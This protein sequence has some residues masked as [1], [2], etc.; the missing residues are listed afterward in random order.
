MNKDLQNKIKELI[1]QENNLHELRSQLIKFHPYDLAQ[2]FT[3]LEPED[4]LKIYASLNDQELADLFS[5]LEEDDSADYLEELDLKKGAAVLEKME[6]DDAADILKELDDEKQVQ[7]YLNLLDGEVRDDLSYLSRQDEKT[8]GSLMTTNYIEIPS[9]V[10]VKEA[11]RIL[12][13]EANET[14]VI[15]PLYVCEDKKLVGI[16]SLKDLIIARGPQLIKDIMKTN[17]VSV[18]VQEDVVDAALKI[19]DYGITTLPVLDKGELV[20]IITIDDAM[21]IIEDDASAHYGKFAG[22]VHDIDDETNVFKTLRK[23]LPWLLGL[24]ALSFLIS[25][26]IDSFEGVIKQVTALVFFQSLILSMAGNI[27]TQALAV[28]IRGLSYGDTSG[29]PVA[30]FKEFKIGLINSLLLGLLAFVVAYL[31]LFI[32]KSDANRLLVAGILAFSMFLALNCSAFLGVMIPIFFSKIKIDPAIASG[33]LLTTLNDIASVVIYYGLASIF[34][35]L[36]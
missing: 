11:M 7:E 33:P 25:T 32:T 15:D 10:D 17:L 19:R 29:K 20:G 36:L 5:Y 6:S 21:D 3:E 14:E 35:R 16:I 12:I 18:D 27:S 13:K 23:R 9:Q 22:I 4:R 2:V 30:L 24:L 34:F 31:F 8:V 28:T 1:E 26:L